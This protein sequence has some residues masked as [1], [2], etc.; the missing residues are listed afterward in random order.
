ML[1]GEGEMQSSSN[2]SSKHEYI[3]NIK[4]EDRL[5]LD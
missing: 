1:K 5:T 2:L 3:E 4:R